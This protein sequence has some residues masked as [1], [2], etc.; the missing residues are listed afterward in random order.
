MVWDVGI[1]GSCIP[2]SP[3]R[4][5]FMAV[6]YVWAIRFVSR[7][8]RWLI[9]G[10]G[11]G[12]HLCASGR[13]IIGLFSVLTDCSTIV[14]VE[15]VAAHAFKCFFGKLLP[16]RIGGSMPLRFPADAAGADG[17]VCPEVASTSG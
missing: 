10:A 14:W 5:E 8:V 16:Q 3:G 12:L 7:C 15:P 1:R 4:S 11:V 9:G 2:V 17:E 13:C 6:L